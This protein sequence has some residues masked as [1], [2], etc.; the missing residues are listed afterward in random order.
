MSQ[1]AWILIK[2]M[3]RASVLFDITGYKF[4]DM[5]FKLQSKDGC[6]DMTQKSMSFNDFLSI[7]RNG[8]IINFWFVTKNE[9][10]DRTEN[11]DVTEKSAQL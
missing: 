7:R 9:A 6:H 5:N 3:A 8:Y 1:K 10:V 11:A 2:L 4:F